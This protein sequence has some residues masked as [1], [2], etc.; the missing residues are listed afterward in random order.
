[1]ISARFEPSTGEG[2]VTCHF[3]GSDLPCPTLQELRAITLAVLY[4]AEGLTLRP[5]STADSASAGPS[6]TREAALLTSFQIMSMSLQAS[7]DLSL[8]ILSLKL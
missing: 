4:F 3:P 2:L 7:M 1:M 5:C 6:W 8:A